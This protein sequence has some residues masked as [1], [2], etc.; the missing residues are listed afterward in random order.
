MSHL[1]RLNLTSTA[2][3]S[4]LLG[5]ATPVQAESLNPNLDDKFQARIG[6]FFVNFD[7][8]VNVSGVD[9]DLDDQLGDS[10]TTAALF[11]KWRITPKLHLGFGYSQISRDKSTTLTSGI[12]VGGLNVLGGTVLSQ[13]YETSSLPILLG[14]SFIKNDRTEFGVEAGVAL[15][16]LKERINI[17][18]PGGRTLTPVN[19]D[20]SEAL[21]TIGL[22]WN[23]ALS[24]EW[25]LVGNFGYLPVEVG[26]IDATFYSAFASIEWRHWKNVGIGAAY[27]YIKADGEVTDGGVIH[28]FEY[29]YDGPFLY[30]MFGGGSR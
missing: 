2:L 4:I 26:D 25:M 19:F 20:A 30:V 24:P 6:A 29:Q 3:M 28:S 13:D 14:Y 27:S 11:V 12:P 9:F 10:K 5:M 22:F 1:Y 8:K 23:Q 16:K 17:T 21:P 18:V 15:T 7:T